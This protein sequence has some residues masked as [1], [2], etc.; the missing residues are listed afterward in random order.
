[1]T[2]TTRTELGVANALSVLTQSVSLWA[3]SSSGR[4]PALHAGGSGFKSCQVHHRHIQQ[5]FYSNG[6]YIVL[7]IQHRD[8]S[9]PSLN[10]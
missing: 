9:N 3:C 10:K 1:M 4:A 8:G 5:L 7:E 6:K 2:I